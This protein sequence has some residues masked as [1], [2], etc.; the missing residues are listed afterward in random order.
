MR[1]FQFLVSLLSRA[2][3][4]AGLTE[5]KPVKQSITYNNMTGR[6]YAELRTS[7]A[8]SRPP[9]GLGEREERVMVADL[10]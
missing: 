1:I 8:A 6:V 10:K 4:P 5:L 9:A 7:A 3:T 2:R